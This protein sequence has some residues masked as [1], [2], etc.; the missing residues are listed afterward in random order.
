MDN[1][2]FKYDKKIFFTT[3]HD[4]YC[5][6]NCSAILIFIFL[7][8]SATSYHSEYWI[9]L[10]KLIHIKSNWINMC[11]LSRKC[12]NDATICSYL[13]TLCPLVWW[14]LTHPNNNIIIFIEMNLSLFSI[15]L[16]LAVAPMISV[17]VSSIIL[18]V[19]TGYVHAKFILSILAESIGRC[20]WGPEHN[21]G[22]RHRGISQIDQLLDFRKRR[23]CTPRYCSHIYISIYSENI[24]RSEWQNK[25]KNQSENDILLLNPADTNEEEEIRE[26][27]PRLH[28]Q[29]S[30]EFAVRQF[31]N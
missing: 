18:I 12:L 7:L 2:I 30:T 9:I 29:Y 21:I 5:I 20:V 17:A 24:F 11:I 28:I 14:T 6:I 19:Y 8:I 1:L 25:K 3:I 27:M 23:Y 31:L 26:E 10:D 16:F 15:F 4:S 22:M 13:I